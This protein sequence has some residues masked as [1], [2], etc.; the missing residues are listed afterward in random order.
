[1]KPCL[2]WYDAK[3]VHIFFERDTSR[4][5]PISYT[6]LHLKMNTLAGWKSTV[7]LTLSSTVAVTASALVLMPPGIV[8]C[9]GVNLAIWS[10]PRVGFG[11]VCCGPGCRDWLLF[12][13]A[14]QSRATEGEALQVLQCNSSGC[15][16]LCA[17]ILTFLKPC[18][19]Q[20]QLYFYFMLAVEN[21]Q[22]GPPKH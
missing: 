12:L 7:V 11:S 2:F 5:V 13:P 14:C 18:T 10:P 21:N 8:L 1:M 20:L 4:L 6:D 17:C 3:L 16:A 15:V 22:N 19:S 9:A